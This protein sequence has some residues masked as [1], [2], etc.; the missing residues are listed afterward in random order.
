MNKSVGMV[1]MFRW[2]GWRDKWQ[3][4]KTYVRAYQCFKA[5]EGHGKREVE[6]YEAE[7]EWKQV[8]SVYNKNTIGE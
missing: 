8:E 3:Y 1:Y 6:F 5:A 7:V 4:S 2:R